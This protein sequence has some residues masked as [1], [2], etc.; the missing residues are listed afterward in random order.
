[1]PSPLDRLRGWPRVDSFNQSGSFVRLFLPYQPLR[2][3]LVLDQLCGSAEEAPD[4][5]ECLRRLWVVRIDGRSVPMASFE[6]AERADLGMRGLIGLVPLTGLEPGLRRIEVVWN[7]S[8][9]PGAPPLDDRYALLNRNYVIP[10][11]FSPN[12]ET[13]VD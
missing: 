11:A 12:F 6:P 5:V 1:M 2:D 8:A 7:P 10:I 13:S 3:N 4:R 9:A